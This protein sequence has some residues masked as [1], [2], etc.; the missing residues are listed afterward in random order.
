MRKAACGLLESR[1]GMSVAG[2]FPDDLDI[3][4]SGE[5]N[6]GSKPMVVFYSSVL[7]M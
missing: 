6:T 5:H 4:M 3:R 2:K 7:A 1:L